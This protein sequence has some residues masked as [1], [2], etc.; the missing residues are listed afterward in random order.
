AA[1]DGDSLADSDRWHASVGDRG[2]GKVG[3]AYVDLKALL[4]SFASQLDGAQRVAGPL[5]L[6]LLKI[7]PFVATL[8]ATPDALVADVS[9]PGTKP[10]PRGPQAGS[11]PL[12]EALPPDSWFAL[13]LPDVG[14]ML[15]KL[16][17]VF[18]ANPLIAAQYANVLARVKA[19]TG[20]D[21]ER[22]VIAAVGDVGLFARGATPSKVGGGLVIGS[23]KPAVLART[24]ARLPA[25]IRSEAHGRVRVTSRSSGFD[26][27]AP[28]MPQPI[29]VRVSD[30]GVLAAYGAAST[31]SAVQPRGRLGDTAL[32]RKAAIAVGQRPT[33]FVAFGPALNLAAASPHHRDD[34]HFKRALPKLQHIEYAAVGVRRDN[35]LD[36]VRAVLGLR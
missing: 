18:K 26:V 2:A 35:G 3:L 31:R 24:V 20:I 30:G 22:D 19:K 21:L 12:I 29:Q 32:F 4:Q 16:G 8:D 25:L 33:L 1:K 28:Q 10:D 15:G 23:Q 9:S 27:S 5:L 17:D 6:G 11:S 13:A 7:N 36:V 34:A 14:G